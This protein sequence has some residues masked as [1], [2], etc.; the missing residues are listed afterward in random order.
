MGGKMKLK[1]VIGVIFALSLVVSARPLEPA[2][3]TMMVQVHGVNPNK[4]GLHRSDYVNGDEHP[5]SC[6]SDF[7]IGGN[8]WHRKGVTKYMVDSVTNAMQG[9]YTQ[10]FEYPAS[11][12]VDLSKELGNRTRIKKSLSCSEVPSIYLYI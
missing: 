12:P 6:P 2:R 7:G 10:T 1:S 9:V 8:T 11:S 5:W 3:R 4:M